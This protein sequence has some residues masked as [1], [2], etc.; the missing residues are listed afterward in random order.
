[1]KNNITQG[2]HNYTDE[3]DYTVP[4]DPLVRKK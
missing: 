3:H 2:V 4:E 1:M